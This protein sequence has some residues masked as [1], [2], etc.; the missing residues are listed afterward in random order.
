MI[1]R[2]YNKLTRSIARRMAVALSALTLSAAVP[3]IA[4]D[5]PLVH[6]KLPAFEGF[7]LSADLPTWGF[8][9]AKAIEKSVQTNK[10]ALWFEVEREDPKSSFL[11]SMYVKDE[12]VIIT[13]ET[14]PWGFVTLGRSNSAVNERFDFSF[15]RRKYSYELLVWHE[16]PTTKIY[17]F[18]ASGRVLIRFIFVADDP[19][20]YEQVLPVFERS[21]RSIM[22]ES[23]RRETDT[24]I[25]S[26]PWTRI[27][28]DVAMDVRVTLPPEWSAKRVVNIEADDFNSNGLAITRLGKFEEADDADEDGEEWE[29]GPPE[30][31]RNYRRAS[32]PEGELMLAIEGIPHGPVAKHDVLYTIEPILARLL[33]EGTKIETPDLPASAAMPSGGDD[34]LFCLS[35]VVQVSTFQ[36]KDAVDDTDRKLRVYT[37]GGGR[38]AC[39][40]VYIADPT[41]F[42]RSSPAI[43]EM[44]RSLEVSNSWDR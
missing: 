24:R 23:Y 10:D 14:K 20:V 26:A 18:V 44:I 32:D 5:D 16:K 3:A 12:P 31:E 27:A 37:G 9:N 1:I 6:V 8:E 2:T 29:R 43:E 21:A 39:N 40:L 22:V 28:R 35:G 4:E 13:H 33:S 25:Y 34:G 17:E 19:T 30:R 7:V 11:L 38:V 42:D 15:G 41:T 36:G